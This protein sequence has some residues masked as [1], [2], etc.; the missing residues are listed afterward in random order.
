MTINDYCQ[1][2]EYIFKTNHGAIKASRFDNLIR[3]AHDRS[4]LQI[5]A[6]KVNSFE[7]AG[8]NLTFVGKRGARC[9]ASKSKRIYII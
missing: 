5:E 6:N 2:L 4:S 8:Y 1:R 3:K 7:E 9:I